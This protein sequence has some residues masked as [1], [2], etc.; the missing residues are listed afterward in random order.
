MLPFPSPVGDDDSRSEHALLQQNRFDHDIA[1]CMEPDAD[2]HVGGPTGLHDELF[3]VTLFGHR[4]G[5][6]AGDCRSLVGDGNP[7]WLMV[8]CDMILAWAAVDS[9]GPGTCVTTSL[10]LHI[11]VEVLRGADHILGVARRS[12]AGESHSV[13]TCELRTVGGALVATGTG[14]FF[15]V[16]GLLPG[17]YAGTPVTEVHQSIPELL[18][19]D[20]DATAGC[21]RLP[22]DDRV[23][24]PSGV[25]HGGV[26]SAAMFSVIAEY[27]EVTTGA[28]V[29]LR[30]VTVDFLKPLPISAGSP[31]I[32]VEAKHVGRR[33]ASFTAEL[34][35]AR[36]VVG[37]RAAVT[38][39][40][41][42]SGDDL[43]RLRNL[44]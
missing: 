27:A 5:L 23:A 33:A 6:A 21:G 39:A 22:V 2:G 10:D 16:P 18:R 37:T 14:T 17:S 30:H 11:D 7:G 35:D 9:D 15:A 20:V 38:A 26:Q 1:L 4:R 40:V 25:I 42:N 31:G 43:R 24:N 12:F 29:E 13:S 36:G 8:L 28:E 19:L 32:R 41:K 3:G 34:A 44:I